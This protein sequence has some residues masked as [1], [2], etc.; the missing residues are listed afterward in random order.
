[1]ARLGRDVVEDVVQDLL[2]AIIERRVIDFRLFQIAQPIVDAAVHVQH[3]QVPLDQLDGRQKAGA[4]QAVL[5]QV[6]RRQVGGGDQGDAAGEQLPEQAI[7]Q[8]G[9]GDVGDEE[10][11]QADHP[12]LFGEA[13]GDD[14]QRFRLIFQRFQFGVHRPHEAVKVDALLALQRQGIDEGVHQVGFAPAHAAPQ[15]Q[16]AHRRVAGGRRF[17]AADQ[18]AEQPG[19]LARS[20]LFRSRH[21]LVVDSL[22]VLDG[23]LLSGVVLKAF[24]L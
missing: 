10:F 3:V 24:P 19:F 11:V 22:Q 12:G 21:Q 8:H 17:V 9:V 4:L 16:P 18:A 2:G 23:P 1:M 13:A 5:V 6:V 14:P 20:R 7:K 15:I